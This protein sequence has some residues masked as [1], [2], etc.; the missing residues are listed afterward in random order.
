MSRLTSTL[1]LTAFVMG[2]GNA[3]PDAPQAKS[4]PEQQPVSS[5]A[6]EAAQQVSAEE[7]GQPQYPQL[8][9]LA[10]RM[11]QQRNLNNA[12]TL[13]T[14]A[15]QLDPRQAE[16]YIKRAAVF[17]EAK[18][19]TRAVNDMSAAITLTPGSAK[20]HNT[21]G[22]F[23][24][25]LKEYESAEKDFNAALDLQPEYP[26]ALNNRGLVFIA[27]EKHLPASNDFRQAIRW[28]EDYVDAHNN[29]GY[30][31]LQ[32]DEVDAAIA[33][34]SKAIELNPEYVNALTNRAQ[35]YLRQE[36]HQIAIDDYTRA[37]ELRPGN[38]QYYQQRSTIYK[39]AGQ[40]SQAED[41]LEYVAWAQQLKVLNGRVAASP[42]VADNW[43]ARGDHLAGGDEVDAAF[44]SYEQA[45]KLDATHPQACLGRARI[46]MDRAEFEQAITDCTKSLEKG[47]LHEAYSLRGD[48]Y[49]QQQDLDRAIADYQA[50]KRI[51]SRVVEAF[52]LRAAK[53]QAEGETELSQADRMIAQA[54]EKRLSEQGVIDDQP[55]VGPR[56]LTIEQVNFEESEPEETIVE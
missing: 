1:L 38:L 50:A 26:H 52:Q 39:A 23:L 29:L 10:D 19:L 27:Q 31:L 45:L 5:T 51:D 6:A 48:V 36:K 44:E 2:C 24:L 56:A 21:R 33:S 32:L 9:E 18:L 35:A 8:I 22:Y 49:F 11:I 16:A 17:A 54:I 14:R 30:V 28:D 12:A 43:V 34:F 40:D 42:K 37:I 4:T 55:Q 53:R 41:D 46:H 7:A 3:S 13:L 20:L 25:L 47:P 15:I